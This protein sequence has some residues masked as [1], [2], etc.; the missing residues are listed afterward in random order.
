M[1]FHLETPDSCQNFVSDKI[2][3]PTKTA[4]LEILAK[5]PNTKK[6]KSDELAS[7]LT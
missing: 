7:T 1:D 5:N 3:P 6:V 4:Q 2:I